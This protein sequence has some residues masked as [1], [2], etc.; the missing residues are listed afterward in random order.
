MIKKINIF[1]IFLSLLCTSANA[2]LLW[3]IKDGI[4]LTKNNSNLAKNFFLNYI[5]SNPNDENGFWYLGEIYKKSKD[6]NNSIKYFKKSYEITS[7]N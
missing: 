3:N 1:F 2:S 7:K 4:E 6:N 5:T